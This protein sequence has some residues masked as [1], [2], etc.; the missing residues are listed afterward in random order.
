MK[1]I[2][3]Y[4]YDD[5]YNDMNRN[6]DKILYRYITHE[7]KLNIEDYNFLSKEHI[8]KEYIINRIKELKNN[9]YILNKLKN[10]PYIEQRSLEWFELRKKSL[11]ASD[12]F[13]AITKNNKLLAKKKAGVYIDNINFNNIAATK[14]GNMFEDMA[15]RCYSQLNNNIKIND[16]GLINNKNIENFAA[17]PDGITDLGIMV[18]IKCPYTRVIKKDII[19]LKY[20]YQVQGQLAVCEL[21]ECDYVECKFVTINNY[22]EYKKYIIDNNLDRKNHGIIAEYF[23]KKDDKFEYLYSNSYLNYEETIV[24]INKQKNE[25]NNDIEFIKQT[26]WYLDNIYIQRIE[27]DKELWKTIPDKINS[28]WNLVIESKNLPI[29]Y[30][31][32]KKK[33]YKFVEDIED[34]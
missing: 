24:D 2:N 25:K 5:Y 15:I 13:E 34:Q 29:E 21:K 12:L 19:P 31:I 10:I 14:W 20:Y 30:K 16:F 11:T 8:N 9:R 22:E 3:D 32:E 6:L 1:K 33:I 26:Y 18:E 28:F 27:F 7:I 23:N 4:K 17:S